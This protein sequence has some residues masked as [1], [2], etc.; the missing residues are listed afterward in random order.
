LEKQIL[1]DHIFVPNQIAVCVLTYYVQEKM[2]SCL[3]T[4]TVIVAGDYLYIFAK[5]MCELVIRKNIRFYSAQRPKTYKPDGSI[6]LSIKSVPFAFSTT[7]VPSRV[8]SIDGGL[9]IEQKIILTSVS[10]FQA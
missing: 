8:R 6:F 10:K 1:S 5:Y 9:L 2:L 7:A 4:C 3:A